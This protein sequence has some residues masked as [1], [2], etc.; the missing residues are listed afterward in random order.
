MVVACSDE[1]IVKY[2][3]QPATTKISEISAEDG[4]NLEEFLD[5]LSVKEA[6]TTGPV[7]AVED[8]PIMGLGSYPNI[9]KEDNDEQG[10][11]EKGVDN[12]FKVGSDEENSFDS[13]LNDVGGIMYRKGDD[14]RADVGLKHGLRR[15]LYISGLISIH[16]FQHVELLA[17]RHEKR[18]QSMKMDMWEIKEKLAK[19]REQMAIRAYEE[20]KRRE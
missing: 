19:R 5:V 8:E 16:I 9:N 11:E 1:K 13:V 18:V 20:D 12:F 2:P 15:N 7:M 14:T 6:N 17:D 4:S 3:K 10:K